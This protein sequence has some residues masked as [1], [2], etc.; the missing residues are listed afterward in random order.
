M[1]YLLGLFFCQGFFGGGEEGVWCFRTNLN[2]VKTKFL[3]NVTGNNL[4][5]L[6]LK[7]LFFFFP[8]SFILG[9]LF[10]DSLTVSQKLYLIGA[11][12]SVCFY[13]FFFRGK[14]S[15]LSSSLFF[16]K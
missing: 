2:M 10:I 15:F 14:K 5:S 7:D 4:S 16:L 13:Q 8:S 3:K 1:T 12:S 11:F 6:L 9:K